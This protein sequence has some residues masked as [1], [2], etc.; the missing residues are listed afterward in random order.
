MVESNYL[1]A[2]V[3]PE[4]HRIDNP[5]GEG[6]RWAHPE[7]VECIGTRIQFD[8]L[9][10]HSRLNLAGSQLLAPVVSCEGKGDDPAIIFGKQAGDGQEQNEAKFSE[11]R[12]FGHSEFLIVELE[13]MLFS[14]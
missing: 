3:L 10:F 8:E 13:N 2:Q 9:D 6:R 11:I 12:A 14:V 5:A 4:L 1:T 7:L